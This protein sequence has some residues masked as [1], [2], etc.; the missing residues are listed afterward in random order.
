[1]KKVKFSNIFGLGLHKE[2]KNLL[3]FLYARKV[4]SPT[5]RRYANESKYDFLHKVY[6]YLVCIFS[7]TSS[8]N[9]I[10]VR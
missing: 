1:V 7:L 3:Q 10:E 4:A 6:K 2:T 8:I 5:D 9:E